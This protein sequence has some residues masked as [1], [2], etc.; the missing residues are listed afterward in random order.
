MAEI[1]KIGNYRWTVCALIFFATTI[2]YLDRQVIGI[3]KPLLESDLNI[4]E[5]QYA[6]IVTIFQ[7]FYGVSMLLA[8]RLI[9]KFGT[10]I[11]YGLSV[12]LWSIAAMGHALAKGVFGF[13]FWRAMLGISESGNFPAAIKTIAEWFPKRERALATGI[14][15]SGTN[16]G[17]ILA[18]IAVPAIVIAWGWQAA[19]IITGAIGFLWIVLWWIF[20]ELPEK[21]RSLA[22]AELNYIKSDI[23]EQN[24]SEKPVPWLQLLKFR[25]TW[26]FFIGKAMTDPIWWFYLF[27]IPGWLSTVRGAGLDIK[28][29]GL[30]LV[31][32]YTS[33][34]VGSIGGGW[35]SSYMIKKGIS[36][37]N[38]RKYTM[39]IFA[40]CVTPVFFAQSAGVSTWGAVALISLAASSHQAWSANIFTTVS[41]SF[42]KRVVSSV[43]SIGG[44][45][46]A[47][48]GAFVS[49]LAGQILNFFKKAGHI[50][51]GYTVMF[52]IAAC[53]YILA[54]LIMFVLA[55]P[56][57]KKVV[58]E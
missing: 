36:P 53:A 37:Y 51:T 54:W 26:V 8:G 40:L 41:D 1:K 3:L 4:G 17:A 57:N 25:Q 55:A 39:L 31:V 19:F 47:I 10:K 35:L 23:D 11:G 49:I 13:G 43:T 16:V 58:I 38:A 6:N 32:I 15:N 50:E 7:L 44:M 22:I 56:K 24:E 52:T 18:P 9:D 12:L 45:A 48:G 33:T 29:F 27:W 20:Y 14:F 42:P 2:N 30:P 5:V 28:S 46:G 21:K 34:T